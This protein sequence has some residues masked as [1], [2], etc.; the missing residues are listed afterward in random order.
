MLC[1]QCKKKM[2]PDEEGLCQKLLGYDTETFLCLDCLALRMRVSRKS[3]EDRILY[4]RRVGC[5]L[6]TPL[7]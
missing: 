1:V 6:F 4:F 5:Q 2:H 7:D 3:L